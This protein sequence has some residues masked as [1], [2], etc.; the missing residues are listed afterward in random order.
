VL[1]L[2]LL[3]LLCWQ[4][5]MRHWPLQGTAGLCTQ[6][7]LPLP[8]LLLLVCCVTG[9]SRAGQWLHAQHTPQ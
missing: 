3:L 4:L 5:V 8:P 1:L 2:L 6:H 7:M 9:H